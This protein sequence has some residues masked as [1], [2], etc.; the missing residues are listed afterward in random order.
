M[1][2]HREIRKVF[3][4]ANART[5]GKV[6]LVINGHHH[7][8]HFHI[9]DGVPYLDLNSA[10]YDIEDVKHTAYPE[11]FCK[12]CGS[13][14][15]ILKWN[16]PLSAVI[17]LT[18]DGG[19]RVDGSESSYYLGV[20]PEKAGWTDLPSQLDRPTRCCIQSFSLKM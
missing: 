7:R 11:S 5:P 10:S 6:R 2:N 9:L 19:L 8:D 3:T 16:D 15:W 18:S 13:A 14:P 12:A 1:F 17:T 4:D 20:T